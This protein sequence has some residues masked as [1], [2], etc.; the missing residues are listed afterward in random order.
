MNFGRV[1]VGDF[2]NICPLAIFHIT[3]RFKK[4]EVPESL[5]S[6]FGYPSA[7]PFTE[8]GRLSAKAIPGNF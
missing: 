7:G 5:A 6:F 8:K 2:C 1:E 4:K 3:G